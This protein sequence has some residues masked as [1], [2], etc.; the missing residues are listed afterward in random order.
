MLIFFQS[1]TK[2]LWD[3]VFLKCELRCKLS[4]VISKSRLAMCALCSQKPGEIKWE[5]TVERI[6]RIAFS[7]MHGKFKVSTVECNLREVRISLH[8]FV[9]VPETATFW[10]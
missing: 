7:S 3:E 9:D 5:E 2:A 6:L 10:G 1:Q 4:F 8:E